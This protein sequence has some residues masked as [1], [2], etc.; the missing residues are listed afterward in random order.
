MIE[1]RSTANDQNIG[2]AVSGNFERVYLRSACGQSAWPSRGEQTL[3]VIILDDPTVC[4]TSNN[5]A[6]QVRTFFFVSN[7]MLSSRY[8]VL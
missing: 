4:T 6:F 3:S 7:A 5:G 2:E 8:S 1:T